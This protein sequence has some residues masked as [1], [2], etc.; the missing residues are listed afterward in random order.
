MYQFSRNILLVIEKNWEKTYGMNRKNVNL[1][2]MNSFLF[3][4]PIFSQFFSIMHAILGGFSAYIAWSGYIVWPR[5]INIFLKFMHFLDLKK[6][7]L[8]LPKNPSISIEIL[9]ID[10]SDLWKSSCNFNWKILWRFW[11]SYKVNL[12]PRGNFD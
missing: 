3:I 10:H 4:S 2:Y 8:R 7:Q 12:T 1:T 9:K 6:N 5:H 11:S